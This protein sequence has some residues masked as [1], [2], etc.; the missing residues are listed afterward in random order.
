M[1][2]VLLSLLACKTSAS[3]F[4]QPSAWLAGTYANLSGQN[5]EADRLLSHK[6]ILKELESSS[7]VRDRILR[8]ALSAGHFSRALQAAKA[9]QENDR[10]W[11]LS[12][13]ILVADAFIHH[14]PKKGETYASQIKDV[15]LESLLRT[16]MQVWSLV[17]QNHN[18]KAIK[19]L[20]KA[21]E[22]APDSLVQEYRYQKALVAIMTGKRQLAVTTLETLLKTV[23]PIP[24]LAARAHLAYLEGNEAEA[25]AFISD[26]TD[27]Q[28]LQWE[29]RIFSRKD[30]VNSYRQGA[31]E[32][33]HSIA[34]S[35]ERQARNSS[36]TDLI[37]QIG[38][39][40][41]PTHVRLGLIIARLAAQRGDSS[42][43]LNTLKQLTTKTQLSGGAQ[44]LIGEIR[45]NT[46]YDSDRKK[47][48]IKVMKN[49][50]S[51]YPNVRFGWRQLGDLYRFSKAY[52]KAIF[53][54]NRAIALPGEESWSIYYLRGIVKDLN[55]NWSAALKDLE[56]AN[57]LSPGQAN[58][59]NYIGYTWLE[60]GKN[61]DQAH[62]M[63]LE[64]SRL[65][66]QDP[67]ITDSVGWG[68]YILKDYKA[69]VT[70]LEKASQR[71]AYDPTINDHLGDA[72]WQA[73]RKREARYAWQ[74]ALNESTDTALSERLRKKLKSGLNEN[75]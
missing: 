12:R 31:A 58:V 44:L 6:G 68:F 52:E 30:F 25:N 1:A 14:R 3:E 55:G 28:R 50:T 60:R 73:G 9:S 16:M 29:G 59:L 7:L 11:G 35:T 32:A 57:S 46:L 26:F 17:G 67:Y 74:R 43:A 38:L 23:R 40:I 41:D 15:P 21:I 71:L 42:L 64:A 75:G 70:H 4:P 39:T 20:N 54:Y 62:E 69:A 8:S 61:L 27:M 65:A 34:Q 24:A 36:W 22:D 47:E 37:A 63:V 48:A 13:L 19:R 33:L 66:P 5:R 56:T 51:S 53:A 72:Y 2:F 18:Q 49:L 10:T 45:S